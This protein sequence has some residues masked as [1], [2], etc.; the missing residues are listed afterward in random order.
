MA[1]KSKRSATNELL[2]KVMQDSLQ[3][4][5][6]LQ[7]KRAALLQ[8]LS[9]AGSSPGPSVSTPSARSAKPRKQGA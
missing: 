3:S 9:G 7:Q 6:A 8:K 1:T 5:S 4:N 2:A